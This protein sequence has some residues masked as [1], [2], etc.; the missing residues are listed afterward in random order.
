MFP[1]SGSKFILQFVLF[2]S[3]NI[4]IASYKK[5][6]KTNLNKRS[7]SWCILIGSVGRFQRYC[8]LPRFRFPIEIQRRPVDPLAIPRSPRLPVHQI[9]FEGIVAFSAAFGRLAGSG[10]H[11]RGTNKCVQ[12]PF[13]P[14]QSRWH[15]RE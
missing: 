14:N 10:K 7:D 13:R 6:G 2:N 15:F 12:L 11:L 4:A 9:Y 5:K 8:Y 3:K 1:L